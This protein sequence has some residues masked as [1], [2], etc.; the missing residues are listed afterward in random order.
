MNN[1]DD[2]LKKLILLSLI[3]EL[4]EIEQAYLTSWLANPENKAYFNQV[5]SAKSIKD[6]HEILKLFNKEASWKRLEHKLYPSSRNKIIKW[7]CI[8]AAFLLLPFCSIYLSRYSIYTDGIIAKINQEPI[9]SEAKVIMTIASGE[10]IPLLSDSVYQLS[11]GILQNKKGCLSYI[12]ESNQQHQ[13]N[14]IKFNEIRTSKGGEYMVRLPDGTKVWLNAESSL[15][16]PLSFASDKREVTVSGEV[17]F[18]VEKDK[19]R[20]FYV[21]VNGSK[22][23]VLG[24]K[25]NIR[26]YQDEPDITTLISGSVQLKTK[27]G[28]VLLK[29]GEQVIYTRETNTL[30]VTNVDVNNVLA[31]HKGYFIFENKPLDHIMRE[32]SR[33]YDIQVFYKNSQ[34]K[35]ERFTIELQRHYTFKEVL[36][37]LAETG[38]I[39]TE[40]QNNTVIIQ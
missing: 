31:W 13:E 40:V 26:N 9:R 21:N 34:I 14:H 11:T 5:T 32:L 30:T 15:K 25:F 27:C 33:W 10:E 39:R 38:V 16:F 7:S 20:P 12:E 8:A 23:E 1:L 4:N 24:T 17:Y 6:K 18:E 36:D 37:I 28:N 2:K 19:A 22:I 3:G 35:D 29:P